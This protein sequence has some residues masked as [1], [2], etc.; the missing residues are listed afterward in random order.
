MDNTIE[1]KSDNAL[2][3]KYYLTIKRYYAWLLFQAPINDY[4]AATGFFGLKPNTKKEHII[5]SLLESL[6]FR[7]QLLHECLCKETSFTYRRIK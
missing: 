2:M 6:V 7:I 4:T 5:R 1:I 3:Q